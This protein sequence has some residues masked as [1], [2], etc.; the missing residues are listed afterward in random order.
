M[1]M[2]SLRKRLRRLAKDA[3]PQKTHARCG[4]GS[5]QS[6]SA[7]HDVIAIVEQ[8]RAQT[9]EPVNTCMANVLLSA[10]LRFETTD[11]DTHAD[12][13]ADLDEP[14]VVTCMCCYHWVSR[15]QYSEFVRM[16]LQNLFWYVKSLDFRKRRNYD[17][18]IMHRMARAVCAPGPPANYYATLFSPAELAVLREAAAG[19]VTEFHN[20]LARHYYA[21]NGEPLFLPNADVTDAVRSAV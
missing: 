20:V 14:V 16:P 1:A 2:T 12:T 15:R 11:C 8:Q 5:V 17:A 18:R 13:H 3:A 6:I 21:A 19:P 7:V 10:F 4:S 9:P